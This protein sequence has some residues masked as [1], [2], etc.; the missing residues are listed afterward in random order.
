MLEQLIR[1]RTTRVRLNIM[2]LERAIAGAK[3]TAIAAAIA[4]R[5]KHSIAP[6]TLTRYLSGE[7]SPSFGQAIQ[8]A[9]AVGLDPVELILD[10]ADDKRAKSTN[11][12]SDFA[13][14]SHLPLGIDL[15]RFIG[16]SGHFLQ[17]LYFDGIVGGGPY[18]FSFRTQE[19][20][21]GYASVPILVAPRDLPLTIRFLYRS[22]FIPGLPLISEIGKIRV[23][24][25]TV[26]SVELWTLREET[27]PKKKT[28][29]SFQIRFW[30]D[31]DQATFF[32]IAE[33]PFSVAGEERV[34]HVGAGNPDEPTVTYHPTGFHQYSTA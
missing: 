25:K 3:L 22:H 24:E 9:A 21:I 33:K 30:Q 15:R 23:D 2:A 5:G 6:S 10:Y 31:K 12:I 8:I 17:Y 19:G 32:L 26:H 13:E 4:N 7:R 1:S 29:T 27:Q 28:Q 11:W 34:I 16:K 20:E 14:K 18:R